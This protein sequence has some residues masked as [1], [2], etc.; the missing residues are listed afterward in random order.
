LE[1]L[2]GHFSTATPFIDYYG[3]PQVANHGEPGLF[4][5]LNIANVEY[6]DPSDWEQFARQWFI[7]FCVYAHRENPYTWTF[8][9]SVEKDVAQVLWADFDWRIENQPGCLFKRKNRGEVP[10]E[11]WQ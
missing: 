6:Y 9:E 8:L 1:L 10:G 4:G 7:D 11:W 5:R 3:G 2:T